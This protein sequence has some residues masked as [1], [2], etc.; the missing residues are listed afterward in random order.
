MKE[1]DNASNTPD[2]EIDYLILEFQDGRV[3]KVPAEFIA[4]KFAEYYSDRHDDT[5]YEEEK[6]F[7]LNDSYQ[8]Y[9]WVV[10]NMNWEELEENAELIRRNNS[11]LE[12]E[13]PNDVE[14]SY[15]YKD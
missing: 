1:I 13:F 12:E 5:T 11:D 7:A 8:V 9:D 3:F 15:G 2:K 6:E 10:G 14:F 4:D